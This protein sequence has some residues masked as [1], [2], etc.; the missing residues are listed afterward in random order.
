MSRYSSLVT[1][2]L[3]AT[4]GVA[5]AAQRGAGGGPA[6]AREVTIAAI[7]GV[8]AAGSSW[9]RAWQGTDNADGL[10]AAPDGGLLFAQEQPGRV[11]KLDANDR[12][13]VVIEDTH[14][15][16]SLAIDTRSL[17]SS[18]LTPMTACR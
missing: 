14:G 11:S 16:G 6:G 1:V 7:P 18:L 9:M 12:V 17:A 3:V 5:V 2:A 8:V 4:L 13:S 15:A 10:V